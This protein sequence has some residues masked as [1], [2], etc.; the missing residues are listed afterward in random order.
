VAV[1]PVHSRST[2]PDSTRAE[3]RSTIE[4]GLQRSEVELVSD[5]LVDGHLGGAA[6]NGVQCATALAKAVAATWILR[7][8]ITV[9]DSVYEVRLE[10][11]DERG[12]TLAIASQRCEICGQGE[13]TELVADRSAAL[14]A[15]VRLLR[16]KAPRLTLRSRPSG[17]EVWIDG[18]P[19]GHTPLEQEL[20]VGDHEIRVE[21]PGYESERRRVTAVPGTQDSLSVT[22]GGPVEPPRRPPWR[23]LGIASVAT[24]SALLGAGVA[25]AAVD[26]REHVRRCNPDALGNCSHRYDTL[27]GGISLVVGGGVLLATGVAALI[28]DRRARRKGS[29][30]AGRW[31]SGHGLAFAF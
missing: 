26:E 31:R 16:R 10:A 11:I 7:S 12:Q 30:S 15:K 2:L 22:L 19:V 24:G 29:P 6:C 25:L 5:P 13:V 14:A 1:L 4:Q 17:A 20:G 18:R 28:V 9:V 23:G 3:L 27:A 21:L 8:T